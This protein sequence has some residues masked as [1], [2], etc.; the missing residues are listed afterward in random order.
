MAARVY[1]LYNRCVFHAPTRF[2]SLTFQKREGS[3]YLQ[4]DHV[5]ADTGVTKTVLYA[6]CSIFVI[7][8][9]ALEIIWGLHSQ[10]AM[11][12]KSHGGLGTLCLLLKELAPIV[13]GTP[14]PGIDFHVC[15]PTMESQWLFTWWSVVASLFKCMLLL[16]DFYS[17]RIPTICEKI[18]PVLRASLTRRSIRCSDL[19]TCPIQDHYHAPL[20]RVWPRQA[21]HTASVSLGIAGH[22]I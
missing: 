17:S 16:C 6:I 9:I 11:S 3:V 8:I 10:Y 20:Y 5:Q 19:R 14:I 18:N 13:T 21:R 4:S 2:P 1:A 15:V 22:I 7:N 12:C